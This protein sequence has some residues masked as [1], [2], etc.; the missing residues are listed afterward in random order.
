MKAIWLDTVIAESDDIVLLD[1][2][3]YFPKSSLNHQFFRD[4]ETTSYCAWK[5]QAR[6]YNVSVGDQINFDAAWYYVK[7]LDTA[8]TIEGRVAFWKDIR[9]ID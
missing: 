2:N 9:V 7:P 1:G 5:G 4:S 6:Y 8:C 3:Y